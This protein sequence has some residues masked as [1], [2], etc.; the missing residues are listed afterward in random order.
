MP[1]PSRGI[2][3]PSPPPFGHKI[4]AYLRKGPLGRRRGARRVRVGDSVR[5][6]SDEACGSMHGSKGSACA[7]GISRPISSVSSLG[8]MGGEKR[9]RGEASRIHRSTLESQ[10]NACDRPHMTGEPHLFSQHCPSSEEFPLLALWG[11]RL[12]S[13]V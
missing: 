8:K 4:F 5:V 3:A 13:P 12:G 7:K 2:R 10:H 6:C 9:R 11:I 1:Y